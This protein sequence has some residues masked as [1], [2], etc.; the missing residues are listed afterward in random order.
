MAVIFFGSGLVAVFIPVAGVGSI[1]IAGPAGI[2]EV[3]R[4]HQS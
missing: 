1:L 3:S 2:F 4:D